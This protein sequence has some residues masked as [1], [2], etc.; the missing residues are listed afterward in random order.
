MRAL[1]SLHRITAN[2]GRH[3]RLALAALAL[4]SVAFATPSHADAASVSSFAAQS[5]R[6][7][8]SSALAAARAK[9]SCTSSSH[10][11]INGVSYTSVTNSAMTSGELL[12]HFGG[13]RSTVRVVGGEVYINDNQA[14]LLDQF[15]VRAP[16]SAH[17]WIEIPPSN[18]N[19]ARFDSGILLPS[20]LSEVAPAGQLQTT[21]PGRIGRVAV[22]GVT[23][24]PNLD[25]GLASG[26]ETLYVALAGAHVPVELVASDVVSGQRKTYIITYHNWGINFHLAPPAGAIAISATRLPS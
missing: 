25:L 2:R 13:A 26:S 20:L 19:F 10:T 5:G 23:G 12:L 4:G 3:S 8:V 24:R 1:V 22:V 18:S 14:A 9:A 21:A 16:Q 11:V 7:I 6:A 17:R 15:S